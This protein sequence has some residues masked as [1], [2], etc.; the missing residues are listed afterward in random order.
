MPRRFRR[1][2][3]EAVIAIA[4]LGLVVA[5]RGC[6]A[7]HVRDEKARLEEPLPEGTYDVARVI[8]GDTIVISYL[9][10]IDEAGGVTRAAG[11]VRVRLIG[12]DAPEVARDDEPAEL[13]SHEA[14][15]FTRQFLSQGRA[16]LRFD[17]RKL[18]RYDRLLAYVYVDGVMLNE[19]LVRQGFAHA[20][21]YSGDSEA[22]ARRIRKAE[23]EAIE[24][25][26][27]LQKDKNK[28]R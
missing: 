26:R 9:R 5:I 15:E 10:A 27:G 3:P 4:V 7:T 22:M 19:E 23:S 2:R 14:T 1:R 8:D 21:H 13:Y 24:A 20:D 25:N 6:Y 18:D 12:I 11:L 28:T 17:G 16:D